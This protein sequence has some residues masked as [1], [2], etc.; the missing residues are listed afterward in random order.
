M[1]IY[2]V[3]E[4][5]KLTIIMNPFVVTIFTLL[6]G[7]WFG[8]FLEAHIKFWEWGDK[9]RTCKDMIPWEYTTLHCKDCY[10][11][12]CNDEWQAGYDE[13]KSI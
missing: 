12:N 2:D 4:Q 7:T 13:A 11:N 5:I 10:N 3:L 1:I 9:C 8:M 6:M